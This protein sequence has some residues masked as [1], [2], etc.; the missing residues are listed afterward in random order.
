M[1]N[2]AYYTPTRLIFGKGLAI[3]TPRWMRHILNDHTL[4][5]F[6][7]FSVDIYGLL[8]L[9]KRTFMKYLKHPESIIIFQQV[10]DFYL[11]VTR[12]ALF[13]AL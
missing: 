11:Q 12:I 6:V 1:E 13:T 4:E 8:R 9:R 7:K 3:I 2:F 10:S 5:R